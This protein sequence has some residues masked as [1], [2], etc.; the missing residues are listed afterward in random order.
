MPIYEYECNKCGHRYELIQALGDAPP[1]KCRFCLGKLKRVVSRPTLLKN[2]G[3]YLFD[4]K[5]GKDIIH[6]R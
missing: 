3:V 2:A 5:T 1:E 6:D 4:R